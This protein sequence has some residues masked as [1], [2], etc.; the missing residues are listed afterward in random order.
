MN[1]TYNDGGRAKAG[2]KGKAGD[3]VCRAIAIAVDKPYQ[4][5][6]NDLSE[7]GWMETSQGRAADGLIEPRSDTMKVIKEYL[8][9][10]GWQWVPTVKIGTGCKV[11]L[12]AEE[13]PKGR[14]IARVS[15]HFVAVIDGVIHDTGDPSRGG[16][17]CVYGYFIPKEQK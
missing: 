3:C 7:F 5:I 13:L 11:H 4:E 8:D 14:L 16:W 12:R 1:F 15:R 6:Y 10:L 9:Y 2:Y 17:R